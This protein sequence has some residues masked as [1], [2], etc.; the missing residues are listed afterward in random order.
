MREFV[1]YFKGLGKSVKA[2]QGTDLLRAARKAGVALAAPCGG[3]GICGKCRVKIEKG[4]VN[5]DVSRIRDEEDGRGG[6]VLACQALVESDLEVSVSADS[7]ESDG[8]VSYQG[9]DSQKSAALNRD[10]D[11]KF[12]PV[13]VKACLEIDPKVAATKDMRLRYIADKLKD[14][15]P[16]AELSLSALVE[17]AERAASSGFSGKVTATMVFNGSSWEA[18]S[19][20]S[21]DS[22]GSNHAFAFDIGT[23]TIAG[24]LIDLNKNL[25]LGTRIVFNKQAVYGSDVITRIVCASDSDGMDKLNSAVIANIN[26]IIE[27]LCSAHNVNALHVPAI[28]LAGNMTMMHLLLKI[29]PS[30]MR[31]APYMPKKSAF[32]AAV[33][34]DIGIGIDPEGLILSAPGVSTYIG[35]DI[36]A[37]VLACG[38]SESDHLSL[39]VDIGT[40]GEI[41]LGDR[42]WMIGSAASA[43]PSFEG[44]GLSCG[45]KAVG[46]AIQKVNI[47]INGEVRYETISGS[48]PKGICG[49]GYIDLLCQLLKTGIIGKDGRIDRNLK[50]RRVRRSESNY[51]FVVA[52][53][54]ETGIGRDIVI[55]DDDIDNLKRSKGAIYSAIIGIL[56]KVGKDIS[57]VKKI[58]IA[59]GF[60]N[61]LNIENAIFIGLLPD[62]D[63]SVYEF[64]GNSSLAGSRIALVSCEALALTGK[65]SKGITYLDLGSEP[66]Y[67]DEYVASLFFPHTDI[68]RFPSVSL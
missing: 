54:S 20:R 23:T 43:G 16:G 51:E 19:V 50:N 45:M 34:G 42:E 32:P 46:G 64:I 40:N 26:E 13:A 11:F 9:E 1:I 62:V 27:D 2:A 59:G 65:I 47:D 7:L 10:K 29:D 3:E 57:E 24:Q 8:A 56:N 44:S 4:K 33:A 14:V 61:Y 17:R 25:V 22:T 21:G 12:S 37:G 28:V 39:L 31:K 48:S 63:R 55:N 36:V 38:L 35:G 6:F 68:G 67:M 58:Y 60:G 66:G 15:A 18:V 53:S 52:F 49:S 5:T 41:V 30:G